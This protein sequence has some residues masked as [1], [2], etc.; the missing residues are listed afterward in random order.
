[1]PHRTTQSKLYISEINKFWKS[2]IP[3]K[4]TTLKITKQKINKSDWCIFIQSLEFNEIHRRIDFIY[5]N[6]TQIKK[7]KK[8]YRTFTLSTEF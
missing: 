1:M 4:E 5:K 8:E 2:K 7:K 3:I 6:K